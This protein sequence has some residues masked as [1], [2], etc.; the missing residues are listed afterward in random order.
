MPTVAQALRRH[1]QFGLTE[2]GCAA[3]AARGCR[4]VLQALEYKIWSHSETAL[5]SRLCLAVT[6]KYEPL[7]LLTTSAG[8]Y[9]AGFTFT[10][11]KLW[12]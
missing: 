2:E 3:S 11:D 6:V 5:V 8:S 1:R 9:R 4:I 7:V 12:R 10:T